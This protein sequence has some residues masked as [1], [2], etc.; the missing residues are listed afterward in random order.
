MEHRERK[1]T[2]INESVVGPV[3]NFYTITFF[4]E[5]LSKKRRLKWAIALHRRPFQSHILSRLLPYEGSW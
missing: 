3:L 2:L 5:K 1:K 4:F